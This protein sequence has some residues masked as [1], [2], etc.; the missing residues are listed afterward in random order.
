VVRRPLF[1][2]ESEAAR[3]RDGQ[4][5]PGFAPPAARSEQPALTARPVEREA[6]ALTVIAKGDAVGSESKAP[7][8]RERVVPGDLPSRTPAQPAE[9][10][11]PRERPAD[12]VTAEVPVNP[13]DGLG[14]WW[15]Q[16]ARAGVRVEVVRIEGAADLAQWR[17]CGADAGSRWEAITTGASIEGNVELRTGIG[18]KVSVHAG[19][20]AEVNIGALSRVGLATIDES[21]GHGAICIGLARG[22]IEV[23]GLARDEF[24]LSRS[25]IV[26]LS[27]DGRVPV[28]ARTIAN[29]D[30][31]SGRTVV[32]PVRSAPVPAAAR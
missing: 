24:S 14:D 1:D 29:R 19:N 11:T 18:V 2:L 25:P 8:E 16:A 3:V 28:R 12:A 23:V 22:R 9:R 27:P 13:S 31:F 30:A 4:T 20:A 10:A 21:D 17:R 32:E 7:I 6:V 5:V 26:V 15:K